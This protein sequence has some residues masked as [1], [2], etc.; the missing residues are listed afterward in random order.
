MFTV[1]ALDVRQMSRR[2]EA[3]SFLIYLLSVNSLSNDECEEICGEEKRVLLDRYAS[4]SQQILAASSILRTSDVIAL[5]NF[6]M[7]L[8]SKAFMICSVSH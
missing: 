4:A 7:F 6:V 3:F 2:N 8:V 5:Q 1:K